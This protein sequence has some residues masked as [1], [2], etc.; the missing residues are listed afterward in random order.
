[1]PYVAVPK[2]L[3]AIKTK[4]MFNLTKRQVYCFSVGGGV[5]LILYFTLQELALDT[6]TSSLLMMVLMTPFFILGLYEKNGNTLEVILKQVI[7][8]K[9]LVDS[10]R[11]YKT[12][13][14]YSLLEEQEK[15]N[16]ELALIGG[17]TNKK[18]TKTNE[19][20]VK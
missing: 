13:N 19:N 15:I 7:T 3:F 20:K 1:M 10:E 6:R 12:K 16:K 5:G 11:P 18:Q 17:K 14:I 4:F 8:H 9:F 2:D